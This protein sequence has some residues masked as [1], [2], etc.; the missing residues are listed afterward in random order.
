MTCRNNTIKELLPA[1]LE[2]TLGEDEQLRIKNHLELCEDCRTEISL[3]RMMIEDKAP[4]PGEAFWNEIP[5]RVYRTVQQEKAKRRPCNRSWL[6]GNII[7]PR[8]AFAAASVGVVLVISW[9]TVSSLQKIS[10]WSLSQGYESSDEI[11]TAGTLPISELDQDQL[12]T[13]AGWAGRELA[14]IVQEVAPIM[15]HNTEM[16]IYD[17]LAE[18]NTREAEQFSHLVEQWEEEG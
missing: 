13:L 14:V 3:L 16:D 6:A 7:L 5:D 1:Y 15:A 2:Q 17:E 12:N 11:I 18:L 10:T 8:W 9:L 4:D